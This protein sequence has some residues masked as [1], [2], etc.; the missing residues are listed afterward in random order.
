[1]DEIKRCF[2]CHSTGSAIGGR[3]EPD[4]VAT[5]IGCEACHGPGG[6]HVNVMQASVIQEGAGGEH[7]P[8]V[9]FNPGKS[10][11]LIQWTFAE[12]AMGRGRIRCAPD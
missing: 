7:A 9:I 8:V 4:K 3:F 11:R 2:S 1:M 6:E 10:G 12:L 5:G